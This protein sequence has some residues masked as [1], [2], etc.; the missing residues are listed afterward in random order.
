VKI[1]LFQWKNRSPWNTNPC[2][3]STGRLLYNIIPAIVC[4]FIPLCS[5]SHH[6]SNIWVVS[7]KVS[8]MARKDWGGG[9][10]KACSRSRRARAALRWLLTRHQEFILCSPTRSCTALS[11]RRDSNLGPFIK[12]YH[13]KHNL[14]AGAVNTRFLWSNYL[15]SRARKKRTVFCFGTNKFLESLFMVICFEI[16]EQ[17]ISDWVFWMQPS[18]TW[19]KARNVLQNK[20]FQASYNLLLGI[21]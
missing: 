5:P 17:L 7:H 18:T 4:S 12:L 11:L 9:G 8:M 19:Q 3:K 10:H 1:I 21:I 15:V 6:F 14:Q 16:A 20:S 13:C 2:S